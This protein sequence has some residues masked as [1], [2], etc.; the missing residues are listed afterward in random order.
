MATQ[1]HVLPKNWQSACAEGVAVVKWSLIQLKAPCLC[2]VEQE[3]NDR[4]VTM[5]TSIARGDV[6][7]KKQSFPGLPQTARFVT[8]EEE[9]D[10]DEKI[11]NS[12]VR[13]ICSI[14]NAKLHIS[15]R[16]HCLSNI[17]VSKP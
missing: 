17:W 5:H 11:G 10:D 16:R 6:W 9:E 4:L 13:R 15:K 8:E 3:R 12:H 2:V 7:C 14:R 1:Q